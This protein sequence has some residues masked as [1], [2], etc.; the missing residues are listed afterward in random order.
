MKVLIF[1][2]SSAW[3]CTVIKS[4]KHQFFKPTYILSGYMN[5]PKFYIYLPIF[6]AL[7]LILGIFIGNRFNFSNN[8]GG[9]I[10]VDPNNRYNKIEEILRYINE[11]YVDTVDNKKLVESTIT[12]MLETLD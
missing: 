10:S 12:S 11:E 7:V 6:F 5:R 9:A 3:K 2:A 8:L 4:S 1:F